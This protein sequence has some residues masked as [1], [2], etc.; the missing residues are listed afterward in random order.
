MAS[1]SD[2]EFL[3]LKTSMALKVL[4]GAKRQGVHDIN[5]ERATFGEYHH[6]FTQLKQDPDRFQV[7]TR[8]SM[9][10]FQYIL[11]K[12]E[13][14]LVKNWTNW[15]R[16]IFPEKSLKRRKA[17]FLHDRNEVFIPKISASLL[18]DLLR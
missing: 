12:V 1:S 7:Y 5:K 17:S 4:R 11:N 13:N 3:L 18:S 14:M 9:G 10:A 16:S 6:L 8:M 2:E 15:H